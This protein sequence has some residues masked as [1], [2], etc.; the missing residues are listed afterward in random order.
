[1]GPSATRLCAR[2]GCGQPVKKPTNKYCSRAC[3]VIDPARIARLKVAGHRRVLPL[4]RQLD[5]AFTGVDE[6]LL[7]GDCEEPEEAP[8]GLSRLAA[9]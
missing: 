7:V 1:M 9:S 4:A 6:S 3:C 8:M 5:L 2:T